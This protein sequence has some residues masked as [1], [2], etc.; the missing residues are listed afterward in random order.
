M[1]RNVPLRKVIETGKEELLQHAGSK[2][3][4]PSLA[5]IQTVNNSKDHKLLSILKVDAGLND[6]GKAGGVY[7]LLRWAGVKVTVLISSL[8]KLL[9]CQSNCDG[10]HQY[11]HDHREK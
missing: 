8:Q 1:R 3:L 11:W 2:S 7:A 9:D 5:L 4:P 10:V 6:S